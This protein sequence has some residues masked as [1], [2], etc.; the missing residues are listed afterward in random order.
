MDSALPRYEFEGLVN[1]RDLGGLPAAGGAIRPGVLFRSDSLSYA[2]DA[3]AAHLRDV[4]GLRTIIDLRDTVE[5]DEFGRGPL[6]NA[7][8]DYISVPCGDVITAGTRHEHYLALLDRRGPALADIVRRLVEPG[9]LPV[10]VHCHVGCDRTGTVAAMLLGLVGVPDGEICADYAR[11]TRA[12][13]AIRERAEARRRHL[14]LPIM[15]RAYY[16]AWEPRADIMAATTALVRERWIDW[17]GW[18]AAAGLAGAEL[19]AL[20]ETLVDDTDRADG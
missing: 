16:D 18:A 8:I 3:D 10:V 15:G 17:A 20:R 12:N 19:A 4:F 11:S 7:P 5:V 1:F 9:T 14:G 13:D 2:T 6:A